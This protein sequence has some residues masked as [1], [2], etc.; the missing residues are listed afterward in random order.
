MAI[1]LCIR[2]GEKK[3]RYEK[4]KE[5]KKLRK[6][7]KTMMVKE[8]LFSFVFIFFR[9]TLLFFVLLLTPYFGNSGFVDLRF[10]FLIYVFEDK[11]GPDSSLPAS[12]T[13]WYVALSLSTSSSKPSPFASP[14]SPHCPHHGI[15][16]CC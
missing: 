16:V 12:P 9:I 13:F 10:F 4:E 8:F 14:L 2:K 6:S 1:V 5:K 11:N 15:I 3:T 7:P